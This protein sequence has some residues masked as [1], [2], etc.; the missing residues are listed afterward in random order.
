[1]M[2]D[3][4]MM[5]LDSQNLLMMVV[6]FLGLGQFSLLPQAVS[7]TDTKFQSGQN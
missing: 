3:A 1:M 6:G 4:R 2:N 5:D 7:K